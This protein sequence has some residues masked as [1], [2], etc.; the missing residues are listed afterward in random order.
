MRIALFKSEEAADYVLG[1]DDVDIA[2]IERNKR[3][4][5]H[6]RVIAFKSAVDEVIRSSS[7]FQPV[8]DSTVFIAHNRTAGQ[9]LTILGRLFDISPDENIM[10]LR[11]RNA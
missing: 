11:F 6:C 5:F 2:I 9:V 7:G 4:R 10:D 1:S 8:K 3:G